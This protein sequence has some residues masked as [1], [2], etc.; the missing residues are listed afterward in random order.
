MLTILESMQ[1]TRPLFGTGILS[2][3]GSVAIVHFLTWCDRRAGGHSDTIEPNVRSVRWPSPNPPREDR[4]Q[5]RTPS[6]RGSPRRRWGRESRVAFR[7]IEWCFGKLRLLTLRVLATTD[8]T[9]NRVERRFDVRPLVMTLEEVVR[10]H[11]PL[12][13]AETSRLLPAGA[14]T[15]PCRRETS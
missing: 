5:Y 1:D 10:G 14:S 9:T 15:P 8:P 6:S 7:Q 12:R 2:T 13:P 11:V 3:L 4:G